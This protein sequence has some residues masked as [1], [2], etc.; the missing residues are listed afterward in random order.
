MR[1]ITFEERLVGTRES[2]AVKV[3]SIEDIESHFNETLER[4]RIQLVVECDLSAGG[5]AEEGAEILRSQ[6]VFVESAYDYFLHELIRLGVLNIFAG[7]WPEDGSA[8]LELQL[9]LGVLKKALSCSEVE[10]WLT[11]WITDKYSHVTLMDYPSLKDICGLLGISV[12]EVADL[13]FYRFGSDVDTEQMLENELHS[14]YQ[15]RNQIAHQSD[16]KMG[17]AEREE[18]SCEYVEEKIHNVRKVVL[19]LCE[20]ARSKGQEKTRHLKIG[21]WMK[22]LRR[23]LLLLLEVRM[24]QIAQLNVSPA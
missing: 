8:Y 13:A 23:D 3:F 20:L 14:L 7:E 4:I 1:K 9:S 10:D 21:S 22:S 24:C 11:D 2:R 12:K 17:T 15:R 19:A 18:I 5:K 6:V 16:R